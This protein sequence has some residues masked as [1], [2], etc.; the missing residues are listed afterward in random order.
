MRIAVSRL[1]IDAVKWGASLAQIAGYA[2]TAIGATPLNIYCFL[3]GITGWFIVGVR[4]NDRAI[5]LIHTVALATM[6]G[7]LI[8]V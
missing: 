2:A 3:I 7:G 6:I 1:G 4:W 8:A 5:M